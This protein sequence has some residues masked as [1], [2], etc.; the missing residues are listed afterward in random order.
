M[1]NADAAAAAYRSTAGQCAGA[2]AAAAI[3]RVFVEKTAYATARHRARAANHL[4]TA[5]AAG[6]NRAMPLLFHARLKT[7][8]AMERRG[9]QIHARSAAV[10]HRRWAGCDAA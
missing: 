9:L 1:R 2:T 8:R 6:T 10:R 3:G 7:D 5:N 4:V